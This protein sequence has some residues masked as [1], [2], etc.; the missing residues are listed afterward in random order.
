MTAETTPRANGEG[1]PTADGRPDEG[2]GLSYPCGTPPEPGHGREIVPGVRWLR[3]HLPWALAHINLYAIADDGGWAIVDTGAQT[4][5]A[6]ANW[7]RA[8][9]AEDA[10]GGQRIT[11]VFVTHMH[12]DHVG[13]AGWLTRRFE[14][15]LWMTRLE[16]LTCRTLVAD[17]GREAPDDGVRFYRRAGWNDEAIEHYR[18]R[19][20]SFGRVVHTLPDSFRRLHDGERLRIGAHEWR[21]IVGNG[22]SP[23]HAC[24][25]NEELKLLISGD[26]V[27]PRISSN[28]S[29][30]P[31][32]PEADPLA[33]WIASIAKLRAAVPDDVLVMPSH[34]EPFRGLHA[35]LDRLASGHEKSLTRLRRALVEPKRAIDVF[36]ALFARPIE[37]A[38][39]LG[40]ATGESI[41]HLNHLVARGEASREL[42][43]DGALRYQMRSA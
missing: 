20:G 24:L 27:L 6:L 17:T 39:L 29:V 22:H 43:A 26:Q 25:H 7:T 21:V 41:A 38:E 40:M 13:M 15:R 3:M 32:E 34:G 16:Y 1:R 2:L 19:F 4:R 5:E 8:L 9:A 31:T 30:F 35:R 10:L 18:V 28:V 12:P 37:G 33:D 11:R 23:E 36:G 42:G 14:A